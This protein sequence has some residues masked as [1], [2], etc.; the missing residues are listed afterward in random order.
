[1]KELETNHSIYKS[2]VLIA[3]IIAIALSVFH[4]YTGYFGLLT[5]MIQRTIH[6]TA[7]LVMVYLT[8]SF[9]AN[10]SKNIVMKVVDIIMAAAS[11]ASGLY[12]IISFNDLLNRLG[13]PNTLDVIF[14]VITVILLLEATRRAVGWQL[15]LICIIFIVYA[16]IGPHLSGWFAHRGF[17]TDR[18]IS[19]LYLTTEG[20]FGQ[21]LGVSATYITLFVLFGQFLEQCGGGQFFI[22]LSYGIA[23]R[24]R[25]GPAKTAVVAS[26]LFGTMSGSAVAN[27]VTTGTFTIPLM[28]KTGYS[29]IFAG[30]VEA[31]ASSGGLVMPPIMGAGAFVM[32]EITGIPYSEI[33]IAAIIPAILLY[34]SVF[35]QVDFEAGKQG[36]KPLKK[37]ELPD[38]KQVLKDKGHMLLPL[39]A[40]MYL[41]VIKKTSPLPAGLWAVVVTI[42]IGL[43]KP[44][45]RL[46]LKGFAQALEGGG[47]AMMSVATACA[48]S[49]ILIGV[50]SLTGIGLKF[51]NT[52]LEI[53]GGNLLIALVLNMIATIILGMGVPPTAAY[54]IMSTLGAPSL[55]DL[56]VPLLAAHLFIFYFAAFANIT[57]PVALA[58]YAAAGIAKDD[59]MKTGFQAFKLGIVAFIVPFMFIYN[60]SVLIFGI[61]FF[62]I[63]LSTVTCIIGVICLSVFLEGWFGHKINTVQRILLLIASICLIKYG[64]YTDII[65]VAIILQFIYFNYKGRLHGKIIPKVG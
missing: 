7:V 2:M 13:T 55:V 33:V 47:K 51:S 30:A 25:G 11:L 60:P 49:G 62:K 10:A 28:K 20:I 61:P 9:S 64:I 5:A 26:S 27:V 46:S 45:T 36:L 44:S 17:A 19:H 29:P 41:L 59:P 52:L 12:L 38:L 22:D 63:L 54:I 48:C 14:G 65:G 8:Y 6:M 42:L 40:I 24:S 34:I 16:Y 1:M 4:L 32:S 53:S 43:I 58:A 3:S 18:L 21:P 37:E 31:V 15:P 39:L 23:G 35:A 56:G 57:P 50:I